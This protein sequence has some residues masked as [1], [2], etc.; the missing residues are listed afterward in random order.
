MEGSNNAR[1]AQ[2]KRVDG[3]FPNNGQVNAGPKRMFIQKE[4]TKS[5]FNYNSSP[6][7]LCFD[8]SLLFTHFLNLNLGTVLKY[9]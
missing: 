8:C 7:K 6:D 9:I 2:P 3:T 5:V 4:W 1:L